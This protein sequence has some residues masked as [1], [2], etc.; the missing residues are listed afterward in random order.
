VLAGD[1]LADHLV[2]ARQAGG[3]CAAADPLG[4]LRRLTPAL[5]DLA[6]SYAKDHCDARFLLQ[7]AEIVPAAEAATGEF[8]RAAG[9]MI[10]PGAHIGDL[11]DSGRGDTAEMLRPFCLDY[12]R[13]HASRRPTVT[14]SRR[15]QYR[16][17]NRFRAA[18]R[19]PDHQRDGVVTA[20]GH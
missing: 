5:H 11:I 1:G 10:E 3:A 14:R 16:S 17:R 4:R 19:R 6:V 7:L 9:D 13:R 15:D 8:N 18:R 2:R 20:G 12:L